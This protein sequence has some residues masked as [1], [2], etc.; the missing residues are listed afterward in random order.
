MVGRGGPVEK[1][2]KSIA[3]ARTLLIDARL[4]NGKTIFLKSLAAALSANGYKC[5][6][7]RSDAN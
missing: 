5:F 7:C 6:L 4:G 1:A 3:S 2:T